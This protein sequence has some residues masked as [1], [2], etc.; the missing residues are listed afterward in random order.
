MRVPAVSA[1]FLAT[2]ALAGTAVVL[3]GQT[4]ISGAVEVRL[5]E[6]FPNAA[7]FSPKSGN[8]PHFTAYGA[9]TGDGVK[10]ISGYAFWTTELDPLERGYDGP[11]QILVGIRPDGL[12]AGVVVGPHRE[13]YGSFSVDSPAF[14]NQFAGKDVR[15]PF[16][17][18]TDVDAISRATISV[19]SATRAIRN[20]ARRVARQLLTPVEK[21]K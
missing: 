10:P 8:P 18:G 21:P 14:A 12:L 4:A 9:S 20:S 3:A 15:D 6:L 11:I 2:Q 7:S 1:L 16:K 19:T 17:V 5:R 13:P